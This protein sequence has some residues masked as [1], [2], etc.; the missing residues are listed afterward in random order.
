VITL[1]LR[2]V[3]A[4]LAIFI[5]LI[6]GAVYLGG[7]PAQA[8]EGCQYTLGFQ[9]LHDAIPDVI[10]DC[11]GD[12]NYD[13]TTGDALQMTQNGMLVWRKFDN[14]TAFTNGF[15]TW[16]MGPFGLETRLN[17]ELFPWEQDIQNAIQ[18]VAEKGY[19]VNTAVNYNPAGTLHVL[20]G[21]QVPTADARNQNA[22]FFADGAQFLGTDTADTSAAIDVIDQ[23][24]DTVT[25]SYT[26]YNPDD[27]M[28][29]PTAGTANVRF[30]FDGVSLT[31]LDPIPPADFNAA[32]SRR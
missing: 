26:L 18:Q 2:I 21:F 30:F 10:G 31:P 4:S 32:G 5:T 22:F 16:I 28:V 14:F 27:P 15:Q 9:N 25:L 20:T 19:Q 7:T 6:F 1:K 17:T 3:I 12:L 23:T 11:A 8:Q 24:S 13:P 29:A